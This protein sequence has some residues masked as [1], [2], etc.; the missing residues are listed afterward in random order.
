MDHIS[1]QY[2]MMNPDCGCGTKLP[3]MLQTPE[4]TAS[5]V[6]LVLRYSSSMWL[7]KVRS[8]KDQVTLTRHVRVEKHVK[9]PV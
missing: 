8:M 6:V 3:D 9:I 1:D 5:D 4:K 2:P 7:Q